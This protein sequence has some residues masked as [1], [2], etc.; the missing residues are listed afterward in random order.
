MDPIHPPN[1]ASDGAPTGLWGLLSDRDLTRGMGSSSID[2]FVSLEGKGIHHSAH[3]HVLAAMSTTMAK[4]VGGGW[5]S[6][7]RMMTSS[8]P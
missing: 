5:I 2:T 4:W 7:S 1:G 6:N 8:M 3:L